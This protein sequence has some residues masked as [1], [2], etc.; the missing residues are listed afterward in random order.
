LDGVEFDW[1]FR[2]VAGSN[3][4]S[5]FS[6]VRYITFAE[7][8][9]ETPKHIEPFERL[10]LKGHTILIEG[11]QTGAATITVRLPQSEYNEVPAE[12]VQLLVLTNMIVTPTDAT[13]MVGDRLKYRLQQFQHGKELS[14][15]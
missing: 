13:L 1:S 14:R 4:S 10:G 15:F 9:Y 2:A 5:E 6:V 12:G 8:P 11:K 3:R 7:S